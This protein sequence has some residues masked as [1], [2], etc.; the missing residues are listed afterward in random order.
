MLKP[1]Q[2]EDKGNHVDFNYYGEMYNDYRTSFTIEILDNPSESITE[3]N[4][5]ISPD[6]RYAV[7][8]SRG[9]EAPSSPDVIDQ[10]LSTF[11]FTK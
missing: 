10:I 2:I 11:K 3:T 4:H 5:V 9:P 7:T 1:V 6:K 8:I